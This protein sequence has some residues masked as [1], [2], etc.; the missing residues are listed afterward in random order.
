MFITSICLST[1]GLVVII[2]SY[3]SVGSICYPKWCVE[4]F[5]TLY[6]CS[7][8]NGVAFVYSLP[9]PSPYSY[10]GQSVSLYDRRNLSPNC[11]IQ[12]CY[13][14]NFIQVLTGIIITS[15]AGFFAIL[16]SC[17]LSIN[18]LNIPIPIPRVSLE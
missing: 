10:N 9:C 15:F 13:N 4:A 5:Q 8:G 6:E 17:V 14:R 3:R 18:S 11:N 7:V 2:T 12:N 1:S 16:S